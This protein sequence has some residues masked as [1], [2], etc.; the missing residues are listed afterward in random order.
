M[1]C[2]AG[3]DKDKA[4]QGGATALTAASQNGH[5][6]VARLLREAGADKDKAWQNGAT[7][8]M[9]EGFGL[10][11]KGHYYTYIYIYIYTHNYQNCIVIVMITII[12]TIIIHKGPADRDEARQCALM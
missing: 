7:A 4:M 5:L 1:L 2:E 11:F 3:A 12:V 10:M 8:L 9:F 6:E